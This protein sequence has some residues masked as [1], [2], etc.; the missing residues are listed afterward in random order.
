MKL[1]ATKKI[2]TSNDVSKM[3]LNRV[4]LDTY[5]DTPKASA[6]F[7]ADNDGKIKHLTVELDDSATA[8]IVG[9]AMASLDGI[10]TN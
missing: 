3:K 5:S 7:S 1:I 9:L 10:I 2:K 4:D 8:Q 6:H